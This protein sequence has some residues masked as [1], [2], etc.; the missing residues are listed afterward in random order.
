MSSDTVNVRFGASIEDLSSKLR[1]VFQLFKGVADG[2]QQELAQRAAGAFGAFG[3][4]AASAAGK[5]VEVAGTL[6]PA[7]RVVTGAVVAAGA[8][9]ATGFAAKK[10]ADE[11][12]IVNAEAEKMARTLGITA[13]EAGTIAVAINDVGSELGIAGA[14][15]EAYTGAFLKFNRM[16]R[17]SSDELKAMGVDV[18]AVAN[19]QK[20]SNEV[21]QEA[22]K[23]VGEYKPGIDQTQAAMKLFGR[24][25]QDV[26]LLMGL[27]SE[28]MEAARKKQQE[29]NLTITAEGVA[30]A[31]A[32]RGAMNDVGDVMDGFRKTIGEAVMPMI[33]QAGNALASFGPMV[34]EAT[35]AGVEAFVNIWGT[36][37]DVVSTVWS[38]ITLAA[39][40]IRA[41]IGQVF[42][43][44]APSSMEAFKT[45]LRFVESMFI[46][47]RIT[48]ELVVSAIRSGLA[49]L[50]NAFTTLANVASRALALDFKGSLAAWRAGIAERNRLLEEGI[51]NAVNIATRGQADLARA[52]M[53]T[54]ERKAEADQNYGNEGRGK[55]APGTGTKTF[56]LDKPEKAGGGGASALMGANLGLQKAE[57]EAQLALTRELLRQTQ[58]AT[59]D[60]Y[61]KGLL[62]TSEYYDAKLAIEVAGIDA[63]LEAKRREQDDAAKA[64]QAVR[65]Q[66]SKAP[67]D[68][69]DKFE[70]AAVRLQTEQVKLLG[71]INVLQAQRS[72]E[73]R[74]AG[75]DF[76]N[77]EKKLSDELTTIRANRA[78]NAGEA[79]I[80]SERAVVQQKLALGEI[81]ATQALEAE[82]AFAERSYT[83]TQ[84]YLAIKHE[85]VREGSAQAQAQAHAE[86]EE[87]ELAHQL[88]MQQIRLKL[89]AE[90]RKL[91]PEAQ[92]IKGSFATMIADMINGVTKLSDVFRNFAMSVTQTFVNLISQKFAEK[93]FDATG[94][95][96]A[97]DTA[98]NFVTTGVSRMVGAWLSGESAK[99]S[100]TAAGAATRE[101]ID[102]AA[103]AKSIATWA[104]TAIKNIAAAA[105]QAAAAVYAAVASIPPIGWILAPA[106][107]IAAGAAVL[108]FAG[109][110]ASSEGGE[111]QVDRDRLNIVHKDETILPAPFAQGLRELVGDGGMTPVVTAIDQIMQRLAP[112]G[113]WPADRRALDGAQRP[114]SLLA[115]TRGAEGVNN[116][117]TAA[118]D[119]APVPADASTSLTPRAPPTE[120]PVA[121]AEPLPPTTVPLRPEARPVPADEATSLVLAQPARGDTARPP[122]VRALEVAAAGEQTTPAPEREAAK[123][124]A[125]AELPTKVNLQAPQVPQLATPA[126][127]ERADVGRLVMN[128]QA[129][130]ERDK[131][132][133]ESKLAMGRLQSVNAEQPADRGWWRVPSSPLARIQGQASDGD[134]SSSAPGGSGGQRAGD[135]HLHLSSIDSQDA[136]R[137]LINN[138]RTI[139]DA[140]SGQSRNGYKPRPS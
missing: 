62:S 87:A 7:F 41:V 2:A 57:Q 22:I 54:A 65:V 130:E 104:M 84:E 111:Y 55:A 76:S 33:T 8:A 4:G 98:V 108:G 118:P 124:L 139:A 102:L 100:A 115:D 26:H 59:D 119:G 95:K 114:A 91:S 90:Q 71:E 97:I 35:R 78:R 39:D 117:P 113:A 109:K 138:S 51:Q 18:D 14:S 134:Q 135:V 3:Q 10:F 29:L 6:P 99:T 61:A 96:K 94:V 36:V 112:D 103:S 60:A 72:E 128:W 66:G 74:K 140:L 120:A 79:E 48:V 52:M 107:A 110:I 12:N 116:A 80:E 133:S 24:S 81:S 121:M 16:L 126:S 85:M 73:A 27:T 67:A 137:F 83:L 105:W 17:S 77:A 28:K 75:E 46:G 5:V 15:A 106:L 123:S 132:L 34:I 56:N 101:G 32:Y 9:I 50:G 37:K 20:T 43:K 136:K 127:A 45:A 49:M 122:P 47:F 40:G 89:E 86:A 30:A 92:S 69:R 93:I 68:Q 31:K 125:A 44:D 38:V 58:A 131:P 129:D 82:R 19:G 21:F 42:G 64:E 70:A 11:A 1:E 53:T 63:S 88:R 23:I 13:S 25:V